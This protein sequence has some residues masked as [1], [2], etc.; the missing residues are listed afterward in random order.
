[1]E[2]CVE[3]FCRADSFTKLMA[4]NSKKSG[5]RPPILSDAELITLSV[6]RHQVEVTDLK[7]FYSFVQKHLKKVFELLPDKKRI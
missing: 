4:N 5:G 3:I 6:W 7:S 2:N 1:M